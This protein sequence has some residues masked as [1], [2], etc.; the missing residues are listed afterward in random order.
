MSYDNVSSD[1]QQLNKLNGDLNS[2][3]LNPKV[4]KTPPPS[5]FQNWEAVAPKDPFHWND[6]RSL[7]FVFQG[8]FSTIILVFCLIQLSNNSKDSKD[9]KNDAIYWGG[10]TGILA[11]WMPAPSSSGPNQS[12]QASIGSVNNPQ[13]KLD[14]TDK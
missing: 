3:T 12:N 11:L 4:E 14:G 2:S 8:L 6:L 7:R 13:I 5:G 1:L 10:V 9:S